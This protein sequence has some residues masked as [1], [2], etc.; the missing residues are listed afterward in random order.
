MSTYLRYMTASP[1][2]AQDLHLDLQVRTVD[3]KPLVHRFG[4][5]KR[6]R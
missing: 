4:L 3:L 2:N 1:V 6:V 5:L